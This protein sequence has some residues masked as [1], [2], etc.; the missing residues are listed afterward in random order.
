[1]SEKFCFPFTST[2][3]NSYEDWITDLV[4]LHKEGYVLIIY[5]FKHFLK[6]D[7]YT[8]RQF[9]EGFEEIILPFWEKDIEQCVVEGKP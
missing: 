1:M 4:W 8:K 6:E 5:N 9:I 3:L 2:N 7:L